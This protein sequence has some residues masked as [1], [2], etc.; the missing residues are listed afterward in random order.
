MESVTYVLPDKMG[1]VFQY[2]RGLL[3]FRS[4]NGMSHHALLTDN[5]GDA[6]TRSQRQ[7]PADSTRVVAH[8]LPLE[9]LHAVLRRLARALPAG[10]GALVANDW[11]ELAMVSVHDTGKAVVSVV[12]GDYAYYYDLAVLHEAVID[13]F[14]TLTPKQ[15]STLRQLLPGRTGDIYQ[16][17]YGVLLPD[18]V[19]TSHPG[20]LRLLFVG[21]LAENKGVF[22]LPAIDREL[23]QR[24]VCVEWTVV[25][26]GPS[27]EQLRREWQSPAVKWLGERPGDETLRLY[28]GHDVLVLPTRAEGLSVVLMEA[29]AAGVVPIVSDLES[30]TR[31]VVRENG[32]EGYRAA[33]GDIAGFA[34]AIASLD[35]DRQRLEAMSKSIRKNVEQN[36]D[37]RACARRYDDLYAR[38]REWKRPRPA[39]PKLQYGS[40]LDQPW[41]PNPIVRA[42][43]HLR[44]G[45]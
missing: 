1:G 27:G 42:L 36:F 25:G 41:I 32:V 23:R 31:E 39:H 11:L 21:R 44:P 35:S 29:G 8:E 37:I 45:I 28:A 7:L 12:H 33:V 16:L 17:S 9:N 22:D 13:A 19:R 14:I 6:D 18:R 26:D 24:G 34:D 38:W 15:T 5:V 40:R 30:G 3:Q 20:P 10:G 4:Q 2:V 43:R